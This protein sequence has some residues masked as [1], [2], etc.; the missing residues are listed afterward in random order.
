[1]V[2]VSKNCPKKLNMEVDT[3]C[4]AHAT[5]KIK[6]SVAKNRRDFTKLDK[7]WNEFKVIKT[8]TDPDEIFVTL[9][10]H[11]KKLKEFGERH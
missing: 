5:L 10:E 8:S 2:R 3:P 9:D 4:Q 11:S 6:H 1:M 7:E